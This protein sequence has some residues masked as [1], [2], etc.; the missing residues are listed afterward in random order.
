MASRYQIENN[1]FII[2]ICSDGAEMQRLFAKPWNRELLWGSEEEKDLKIWNRSSP[3]LF[4]IVGKLKNDTY[5]FKGKSYQMPQHGFAR[6]R[7][8]SCLLCEPCEVEFF[9]EADQETFKLYPFCFELRVKYVLIEQTLKVFYEVKN[10]DRQ[11]IFFSIGAHPAFKTK[12]LDDYE[13]QFE[14]EENNFYQLKNGLVEWNEAQTLQGKVLRPNKKLFEKDALIFK[15]LKSKYI[16]LVDR[17]RNEVIRI[18]GTNTPFF[19]IWGKDSVPFICLEPWF[20]VSDDSSHDQNLE[21]KKGIQTLAMGETFNFSY[22]IE[23]RFQETS[24]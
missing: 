24:I 13:I 23:L 7:E 9:L 6:D 8:F 15:D 3:I 1:Y 4:P 21:N 17:K 2:E 5:T 20:G 16:D 14:Q 18:N 11:D 10:V 12:N 22:S 19:G